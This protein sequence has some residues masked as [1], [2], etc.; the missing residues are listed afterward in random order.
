[1]FQMLWGL[2]VVLGLIFLLY[3]LARK[4]FG[5]GAMRP[6]AIKVLEMRYLMPR[7]A[8]AL[9]EVRGREFLIG[10]GNGRIELLSDLD[11]GNKDE[12]AGSTF[13]SL[14]NKDQ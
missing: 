8:L 11:G 10:V 5:L 12:A 9:V 4:R 1:M 7:T 3:G 13:Q 6:G 2:L 14:L